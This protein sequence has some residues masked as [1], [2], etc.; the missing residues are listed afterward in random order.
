MATTPAPFLAS[1]TSP[2]DIVHVTLTATVGESLRGFLR[3][4]RANILTL[5]GFVILVLIIVSAVV[6]ALVPLLTQLVLG[7][8]LSVLPYDPNAISLARLQAPSTAHWFGTDELGR[9]MFSRVFVALPLDLFIG[10]LITTFAIVVGGIIGLISGFWD[11]PRSWGGLS[12]AAILRVTDIFLAFPT[13]VLALAIT[14]SIGGGLTAVLIALMATWWPYYVRLVRGEV[15]VIKHQ[16][17]VTAARAA[18]VGEGRILLRHVLR[19]L[20]EP[21][22]VYFTL[23]IGSVLVTFSTISFITQPLPQTI[24]EWGSMVEFYQSNLQAAPWTVLAPGAAI[25]IAVLAFSLFGDGMRE[26]LDPRTRRAYTE[27]QAPIG[28]PKPPVALAEG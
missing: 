28:V 14:A 11:K 10:L 12:S 16:A 19:N 22:V 26:I 21:L 23:D 9:D 4:L 20:I 6:V 18:G 15:L 17:Y 5:I 3:I 1:A 13:L 27:V 25:F 8:P 24:P 2:R 7:H